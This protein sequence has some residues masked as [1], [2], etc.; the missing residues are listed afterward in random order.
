MSEQSRSPNDSPT[1]EEA[2]RAQFLD[3][4]R[5]HEL[6][7]P[8]V[9]IRDPEAKAALDPAKNYFGA[10]EAL[11]GMFAASF[12]CVAGFL[13]TP[14]SIAGQL[15]LGTVWLALAY[16]IYRAHP[17]FAPTGHAMSIAGQLLVG[18]VFTRLL[19]SLWGIAFA[20]L[21]MQVVLLVLMENLFARVLAAFAGVVAW[22]L[23]VRFAWW[24]SDS[25][26]MAAALVGWFVI[27][28]PVLFATQTLISTERRWLFTPWR[29]VARAATTGM[30]FALAY[31]TWASMPTQLF[32]GSGGDWLALWPLLGASAGLC[33]TIFAFRLR[34]DTLVI[35]TAI[36]VVAH[37]SHFYYQL[38]TTLLVKSGLM[39]LVGASMLAAANLLGETAP[40]ERAVPPSR[41]V[42]RRNAWAILA[43]GLLVALALNVSI[44]KKEKTIRTGE[45]IFLELQ[46]VDPRSIMQGDYMSLRFT[47]MGRLEQ[48]EQERGV[49]FAPL[50]VDD[51][52]VATIGGPSETRRIRYVIRGDR[53]AEAWIGTNA[54]FFEEGK[55]DRYSDARY[56]EFRLDG[57]SGEAVLVGLRDAE[58]Q[59]I[60]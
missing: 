2:Q 19:G 56:G 14:D 33:G 15:G 28:V 24:G 31:G 22:S 49:Y 7:G 54:Y 16:Y 53:P 40:T 27:W 57:E 34:G 29:P 36:G 32:S 20:V 50:A 13:L 48:L 9:A 12:F 37:V 18:Y 52:G 26:T 59:A 39:L 58:L 1:T 43:A 8:D 60:E 21:A 38:G 44:Y 55:R 3:A 30:I 51:R 4:L 10:L 11:A 25:G 41:T 17:S 6:I 42:H 35:A 5:S 45:V 23:L 47:I 46:P